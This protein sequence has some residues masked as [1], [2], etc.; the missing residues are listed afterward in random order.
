MGLRRQIIVQLYNSFAYENHKVLWA[1]ISIT[2][3]M[4]SAESRSI[5]RNGKKR[6][7]CD[8]VHNS[9]GVV[10]KQWDWHTES[11]EVYFK[12]TL[13]LL[14]HQTRGKK[15]PADEKADLSILFLITKVP[16]DKKKYE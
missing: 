2:S 16:T 6:A 14:Q 1:Q 13:I 9:R 15:A 10:G 7:E 11:S 8:S 3:I 5:Y 4:F 12:N